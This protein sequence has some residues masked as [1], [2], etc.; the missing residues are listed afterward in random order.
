MKK[1]IFIQICCSLF[2]LTGCGSSYLQSETS[3]DLSEPS[4]K[5]EVSVSE[6]A[7]PMDTPIVEDLANQTI[8]V[9]VCGAVESP[10]V[11]ELPQDSRV[12]KAIEAAGGLLDEAD[13]TSV[14]L[15]EVCNDGSVIYV[16][17]VG[18][19]GSE[20]AGVP[21]LTAA[22]DDGLININTADM[23]ELSKLPG[24]GSAKATQIIAYRQANGDFQQIEDIKKVPGIK[25][26][27]YIPI[28]GLIKVK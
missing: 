26:G 6:S 16:Y 25:D 20:S 27:T 19:E 23:T 12:F 10:G 24:I 9:Q 7:A 14:N 18:E 13:Y 5:I 11:Y 8:F 22:V 2:F 15:A 21:N 17:R 1:L 28:S 3:A 4:T